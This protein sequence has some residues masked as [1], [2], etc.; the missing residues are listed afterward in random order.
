MK[1]DK[2]KLQKSHE[3]QEEKQT[4]EKAKRVAKEYAARTPHAEEPLE[5]HGEHDRSPAAHL[6]GSQGEPHTKPAGDLRQGSHPGARRQ[7]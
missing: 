2:A 5:I 7:P 1:M 6:N 4:P 3:K